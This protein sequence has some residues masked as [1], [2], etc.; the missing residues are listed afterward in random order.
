[1]LIGNLLAALSA[2]AQNN[3]VTDWLSVGGTPT[4]SPAVGDALVHRSLLA[5]GTGFPSGTSP[6]D[7]V[8]M[9]NTW[10][11]N[12]MILPEVGNSPARAI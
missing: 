4:G 3:T 1:M 12:Q 8:H 5:G 10:L 2:L 6:G 7:A 11:Y 9:G